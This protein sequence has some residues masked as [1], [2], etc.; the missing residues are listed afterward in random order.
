MKWL[1]TG[2]A[3]YIGSHVAHALRAGGRQVV[4]LDDLST[5]LAGRL[6]A[7]IEL[8]RS[9]VLD[10]DSVTDTLK[11]HQ[12]DGV[13]HLAGKKSVGD[14]VAR[15]GYYYREN[16]TG[17]QQL[18][19]AMHATDVTR[20]VFSSSAAVYGGAHGDGVDESAPT[21]PLSPYG[22]TKLAGE[23][24]I[25]FAGHLT[26]VRWLSLR[27]FNVAGSASP[28]LADT[29]VSNLIPMVFRAL[30][31]GRSPQIFGDDYPT[32]DGSCVRD[33][34]HVADLAD[35]HVA[36]AAKL[37]QPGADLDA[38]YNIGTGVGASV[39]EV[40]SVIRR[41]TERPF[42]P[43]ITPRRG[44]D[45]AA[46]VAGVEAA[47]DALGWTARHDLTSMIQSAWTGWRARAEAD[48]RRN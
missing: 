15:P 45:P 23:D 1:L 29:A 43:L 14:S 3:G 38:V 19:L 33:Y 47:R 17:L 8:V 41:V 7:D 26:G 5:G 11:R 48:D 2:G 36:A 18:L 46:V 21:E 35:A 28:D 42:E 6:P 31:E 32:A 34:I 13:I 27:Y 4:V 44:G 39:K 9:S 22:W 12:V 37:E 30:D 40:L 20:L 24:L 10:L 16:V 25:R